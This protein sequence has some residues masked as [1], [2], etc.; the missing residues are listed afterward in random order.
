[1][2][3]RGP[4]AQL[5]R[6]GELL[7][8]HVPIGAHGAGGFSRRPGWRSCTVPIPRAL[9]DDAV[10]VVWSANTALVGDAEH[11]ELEYPTVLHLAAGRAAA[12][13]LGSRRHGA[14]A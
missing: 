1:M 14:A 2:T 6:R 9:R 4:H 11:A 13:W 12:P 3:L 5:M 8:G 7:S 10:P